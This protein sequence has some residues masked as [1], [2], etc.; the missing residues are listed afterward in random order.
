MKYHLIRFNFVFDFKDTVFSG[1]GS[2]PTLY[3]Q[4]VTLAFYSSFLHLLSVVLASSSPC[5]VYGVLGIEPM[6]SC[7]PDSTA[8]VIP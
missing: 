7:M 3:S 1:P 5:P 8:Q 6:A 4:K 2:P